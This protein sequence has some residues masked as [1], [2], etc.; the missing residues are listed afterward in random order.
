[1]KKIAILLALI[2][3][4]VAFADT[5]K[6][7]DKAPAADKTADKAPA[8]DTK[9]APKTDAKTTTEEDHDEVDRKATTTKSTDKAPA[10]D[11]PK[12]DTTKAPAQELIASVSRP[13]TAPSWRLFHF[14][15]AR[16]GD[17]TCTSPCSSRPS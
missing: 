7:A 15:D 5:P 4:P 12:A 2:A 10:K 13:E 16:R 11:A 9:D 6:A 17:T 3:T 14:R 8:G 1:M